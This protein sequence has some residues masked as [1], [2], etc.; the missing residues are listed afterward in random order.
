MYGKPCKV[1]Q[2][3]IVLRLYWQYHLKHT[4]DKRSRNCCDGPK[5][6]TSALHTV[7]STYS[8]CVDQLVQRLFFALAAMDDHKVYGG[9]VKD[10]L[11][12][13][14]V[15]IF[16]FTCVLMVHTLSGRSN[17][18]TKT[19]T[20]HTFFLFSNV[21]KVTL[22]VVRFTNAISIKFLVP[23]N[24][25]SKLSFMIAASIRSHK[26]DKRYFSLGK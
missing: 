5:R 3:A 8:S 24:L 9:D 19:S 22:K 12:I 13:V 2:K 7:T 25:I 16:Q 21:F 23:K 14:P 10:A 4:S 11:P 18:T 15:L 6:A 20:V 1:P 26:K 17:V